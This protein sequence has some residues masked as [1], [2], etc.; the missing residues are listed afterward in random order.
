MNAKTEYISFKVPRRP[1]QE[2][3]NKSCNKPLDDTDE[4]E[5]LEAEPDET[6]SLE[7]EVEYDPDRLAS[8]ATFKL[9]DRPDIN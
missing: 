8:Y 6:S 9:R 3:I 1:L 2:I 7:R 5:A 4:D